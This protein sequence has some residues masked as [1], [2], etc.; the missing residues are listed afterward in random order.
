ME[1][2]QPSVR[3]L[4]EPNGIELLRRIE[5]IG[6]V[7]HRSEEAQTEDSY[8]RFIPAVV[9]DKGDWSITEHVSVTVL[10][11]VDRATQQQWTRHRLFSFTIE[12]TRFVNYLKKIGLRAILPTAFQKEDE[13]KPKGLSLIEEAMDTA[14]AIYEELI[15][16]GY[17]PQEARAC[18][19]LAT[20]SK[21]ICTGNLRNWRHFFIM[22]TT[23][24]TQEDFRV[25]AISLLRQFQKVFPY[26]YDDIMP[27]KSQ[28]E[29]LALPR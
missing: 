2:I 9:T 13:E 28:R 19:P 27:N 6:R 5:S 18:L 22:R 10:A 12:S 7:S 21:I 26:L 8:T 29:A 23:R 1:I 25:L 24:E 17:K 4:F 3:I 16:L 15:K 14:E 20:A 11:V